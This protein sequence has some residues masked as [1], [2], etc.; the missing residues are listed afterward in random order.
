MCPLSRLKRQQTLTWLQLNFALSICREQ[1]DEELEDVCPQNIALKWHA[2]AGSGVYATPLITDLFSDGKKDIV[3]P[4]FQHHLEVGARGCWLAGVCYSLRFRVALHAHS[5][6]AQAARVLPAFQHRLE[7]GG[8][9]PW[10]G[11]ACPT[12]GWRTSCGHRVAGVAPLDSQG[13]CHTQGTSHAAMRATWRC[14]HAAPCRPATSQ[15]FE[16]RDGAKAPGFEAFHA[17]SAHTS[18]LL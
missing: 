9:W 14:L 5:G 3:V 13:A 15:V 1:P 4:A 8:Q 18:P 2:E 17:S 16:G 12:A 6:E 11:V 10:S 7:V